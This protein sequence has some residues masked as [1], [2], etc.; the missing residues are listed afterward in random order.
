M[1][2]R[3]GEE[4]SFVRSFSMFFRMFRAGVDYQTGREG[5]KC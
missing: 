3:V 1:E 4:C 5:L 2:G